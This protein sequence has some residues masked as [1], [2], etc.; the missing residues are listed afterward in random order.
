MEYKVFDNFLDK[1][2]VK[3]LQ[4]TMLGGD[5]PW[6][7]KKTKVFDSDISKPY[8]FQFT[9]TFYQDFAP[10]SSYFNLL[11]PLINKMEIKS[12]V[13]IKANLTTR[14][15]DRIV[16][17]HHVDYDDTK[18]L[19]TAVFYLNT[20]DGLTV[21]ENGTEIESIE[22][23]LLV[24]DSSLKHSGTSSTNENARSVININYYDLV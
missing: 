10:T 3:T 7:Y 24:F 19:K 23:R 17:G 22:N 2:A 11:F 14:T 20:N 12:L 18:F 6:F 9:H 4:Q 16:Y 21:F 5:F 8:L 1:D 13:R 15:P